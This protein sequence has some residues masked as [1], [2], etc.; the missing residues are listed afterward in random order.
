VA[1]VAAVVCGVLVGKTWF[2]LR[3]EIHEAEEKQT[4]AREH[5]EELRGKK[6]ASG[7]RAA[8][9]RDDETLAKIRER[10]GITA[11]APAP[12]HE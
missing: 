2:G 12:E 4:H 10:F 6:D 9:V 7:K 5:Y 8:E 11:G 3:H 1:I